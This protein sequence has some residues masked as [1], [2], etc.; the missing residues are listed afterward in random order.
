MP[1]IFFHKIYPE[2]REFQFKF[3]NSEPYIINQNDPLNITCVTDT[4]AYKSAKIDGPHTP[5]HTTTLI[6]GE[7][8]TVV[9]FVESA[10]TISTGVF[11]CVAVR[12]R[13]NQVKRISLNVT[14]ESKFCVFFFHLF[15]LS[16][17]SMAKIL[18]YDH[19]FPNGFT[20]TILK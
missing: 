5:L 13:D 19:Q 3:I 4:H 8:R 1:F 7:K 14:V 9:Y 6:V 20:V 11:W 15:Y 18:A 2:E 16:S 17:F 10:Q 12:T